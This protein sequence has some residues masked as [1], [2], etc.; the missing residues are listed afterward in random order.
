MEIKLRVVL[1]KYIV[2]L[3]S[4]IHFEP[5]DG[6]PAMLGWQV[7]ERVSPKSLKSYKFRGGSWGEEKAAAKSLALGKYYDVKLGVCWYLGLYA[8]VNL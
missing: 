2:S 5:I 4:M 3:S 8:D 7:S 1:F 6:F